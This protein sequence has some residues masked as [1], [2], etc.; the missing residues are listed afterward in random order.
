MKL[1]SRDQQRRKS[2]RL[3]VSML[4]QEETFNI[5]TKKKKKNRCYYAI[6]KKLFY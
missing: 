5:K 4:T 1:N 6:R 3:W 2:F